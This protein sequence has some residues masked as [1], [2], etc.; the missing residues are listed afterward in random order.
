MITPA[1][2]TFISVQVC[3]VQLQMLSSEG[4]VKNKACLFVCLFVSGF[5][6]VL[7]VFRLSPFRP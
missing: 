2:H 4:A 1:F 7:S 3:F 5:P 6:S